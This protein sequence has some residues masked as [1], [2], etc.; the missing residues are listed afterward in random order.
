M[1]INH[2]ILYEVEYDKKKN[3]TKQWLDFVHWSFQVS[4][5]WYKEGKIDI[6][7]QVLISN[8]WD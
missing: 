3:S 2:F 7:S 5:E 4:K 6:I 8:F 1:L